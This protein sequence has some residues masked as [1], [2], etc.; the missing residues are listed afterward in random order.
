MVETAPAPTEP[1]NK[2]ATAAVSVPL[3]PAPPREM[4][5]E[6][7]SVYT[8]QPLTA[9]T[10]GPASPEH[11]LAAVP[12]FATRL[13]GYCSA[14][15]SQ[16]SALAAKYSRGLDA[17]INLAA[18]AG[19]LTS[20]NAFRDE[21]SRVETL[22][23]ALPDSPTGMIE[24]AI[25]HTVSAL[26]ELPEGSPEELVSLRQTWTIEANKIRGNLDVALQRSLEILE[27][28]LTRARDFE[29]ATSIME[30]RKN[31]PTFTR[32]IVVS[33][34]KVVTPKEPVTIVLFDGITLDGWVGVPGPGAFSVDDGAI[35]LEGKG[36]ELF[37]KGKNGV[38]FEV[39]DFELTL[40]AQTEQQANS[41][42]FFHCGAKPNGFE[43]GLEVQIA[44][45]NSDPRKTG[46]LWG[47]SDAVERMPARD[48][49]WFDLRIVVSGKTVSSHVDGKK[50]MEWTEPDDWTPPTGKPGYRIGKGT[51]ALQANGGVTWIKDIVLKLPAKDD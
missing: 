31:L 1:E 42:V 46:T 11:P 28:E 9:N 8:I 13:E 25:D 35:R 45:E 2:A 30:F 26:P 20:A 39:T 5:A 47:I 15:S 38:P 40:T 16:L 7:V 44:N 29:K 41:G 51:F 12:G 33:Q 23:F 10:E 21:K 50:L 34:E 17:Q 18:D 27:T 24:S 4:P 48:G 36:G 32:E 22:S 14:R 3:V 19:D 49:E 37:Y 43:K 6:A